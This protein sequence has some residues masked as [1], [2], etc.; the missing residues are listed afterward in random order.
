[1][2]ITPVSAF[3][4]FC[5]LLQP[6]SAASLEEARRLTD[7]RDFPAAIEQF[8]QLVQATP[9][10]ADL[11]IEAAR[12]N[13]WADR[14]AE[15]AEL[16]AR[17]LQVAPQRLPDIRGAFA[18]QL[19]W[20]GKPALALAY[21]QDELVAKPK[22]REIRHGLAEA[23]IQ[24]NDLP[25]ALENYREQ[26]VHFPDD[27][28]AQKGE[29]R[30]LAWLGR[31]VEARLAWQA[32][33]S[34]SPS[35][36][37]ARF[38]LARLDNQNGH[39]Q[40]AARQL[41]GLLSEK[42]DA[43]IRLELARAL[44][45]SGDE[46]A[47]RETIA[48]LQ[49]REVDE[50]RL[51]LNSSLQNR[52]AVNAEASRDSD[53]L[54]VRGLTAQLNLQTGEW[55]DMEF[56]MRHARLSQN[57]LDMNGRTWLLGYGTQFGQAGEEYGLLFPRLF[58]GMREFGDWH[59]FAWMARLKWL[60]VDHWRW[61]FEAGNALVE[62]IMAL[63]NHV[64]L[65]YVSGGF[66]Y[67]FAPRWQATAGLLAGRFDDGNQRTRLNGR[68]EYRLSGAP[69][70]TLGAEAMAFR[71]SEP[72]NPGRGY[73]SPD[74]YRELKLA[75]AAEGK[76]QGWDLY[77]KTAL[78][79]LWEDPGGSNT[80]YQLEVSARHMVGDWGFAR[81]YGGYSDSAG[82]T[83]GGGGYWRWYLGTMLDIPF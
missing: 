73:W 25:K 82:L 22:D 16:Y 81:F 5:G 53:D 8:N 14:N 66:D 67:R 30:V 63:Q 37:E 55:S 4:L 64:Q 18:W 52:V 57:G 40:L 49:G 42:E 2:N 9:G 27:A 45:W 12:V 38:A 59:S 51:A 26:I 65:D 17:V 7:A 46:R 54:K 13:G 69:R 33:L 36:R 80:L 75:L 35:D 20:S 68:L 31:S 48:T 43:G 19:L 83:Q 58:L 23:L 11:L 28:K 21:F 71:D 6:V 41:R 50:L 76:H 77:L 39:H 15:A 62:N 72:P 56:S 44:R 34:R 61:D 24:L 74:S 10:N 78:G 29:A 60:P 1:M 70:V 79:K 3:L 47:A 32:I